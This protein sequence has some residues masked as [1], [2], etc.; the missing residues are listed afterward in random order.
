MG[1][2]YY[3]VSSV[4]QVIGCTLKNPSL[5]DDEGKYFYNEADFANDFHRVVFGAINNLYQMGA[6]SVSCIDIENYF[7]DRPQSKAIYEA[8]KGSTW[9]TEVLESTD[10]ANFDYYYDRMKKMTLLRSYEKCGMDMRFLYD[11]NELFDAKKKKQQEDYLDSLSLNEIADIIDKKI[12]DIR[13]HCIDNATDEAISAGSGIFELLDKL[14]EE[15]DIGTGL[16]DGLTNTATRGARLGKFY[17]RSAPTGI[18]KTRSMIADAATIAYDKVYENGAWKDNGISQPVLFISTE[19]ELDEIQTMLL[20]FVAQVDEDHIK[21]NRYEFDEE[22]RV[23]EAAA[24]IQAQPLY[25]EII[26]DFSLKDIENL[27]KRSIRMFGT[28]YVFYDYLHSSMKI[29]EE[30]SRRSGGIKLREDNILFLLSVKLKDICTQ[31]NVFIMTS[32]QLNESWKTD[33]VPDQNLLRGAKSISDKCDW[34]SILLNATPQDLE[35]VKEIS[36]K[37]NCPVPNMKLSIY[38]N[39]GGRYTNFYLW[40]FADKSTCRYTSIFAT[41][42][43]YNF[44]PMKETEIITEVN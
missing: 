43:N 30:I 28:K 21:K 15:P 22:Q 26:P 2:Q 32:T 11:P 13:A 14:K 6:K 4:V 16:Y 18:G 34:G 1:S 35:N 33:S 3:D 44:I 23:R 7:Q 38:K 40:M 41:D 10:L 25:V 20:A 5:L 17:I 31:F 19:M 8:G 29:L 24:I 36:E 27:I 42:Y 37:M 39:R 12:F 9:L